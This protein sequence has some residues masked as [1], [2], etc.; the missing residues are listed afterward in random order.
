MYRCISVD[1]SD[2]SK[3]N[4]LQCLDQIYLLDD[5]N[6]HDCEHSEPISTI[7]T[8]YF[9]LLNLGVSKIS[10]TGMCYIVSILRNMLPLL[11]MIFSKYNDSSWWFDTFIG[12]FI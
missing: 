12:Y 3:S 10:P 2:R 4:A 1:E 5:I 6:V 8:S 9:E 7:I 11:F